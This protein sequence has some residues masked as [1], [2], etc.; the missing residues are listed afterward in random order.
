MEIKDLYKK[1][2]D[3]KPHCLITEETLSKISTR[4]YYNGDPI[5]IG[6]H[7]LT[8]LLIE[9]Y[10]VNVDEETEEKSLTIS[11]ENISAPKLIYFTEKHLDNFELPPMYKDTSEEYL[12]SQTAPLIQLKTIL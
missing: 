11:N 4:E 10:E 12:L 9:G 8:G 7:F 2:I 1:I 5:E 3:K 6:D